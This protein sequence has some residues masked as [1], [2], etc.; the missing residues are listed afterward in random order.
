MRN[1][2]KQVLFGEHV[3][4]QERSLADCLDMLNNLISVID[5]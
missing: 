3:L 2:E 1:A 5:E 4:K